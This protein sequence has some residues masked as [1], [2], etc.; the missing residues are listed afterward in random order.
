VFSAAFTN[1]EITERRRRLMQ[2]QHELDKKHFP[3]GD[4]P[5]RRDLLILAEQDAIA[6]LEPMFRERSNEE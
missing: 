1:E 3:T 6:Y 2:L 4:L 5:H